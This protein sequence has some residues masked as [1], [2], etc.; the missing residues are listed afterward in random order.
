MGLVANTNLDAI[1]VHNNLTS[2][3]NAVAKSIQRLSSGLRVN[4]AKDDASGFAIAN[5]FKAKTSAMRVASQNAAEGQSMLQVADGGYN[6][7]HEI[8]I[9]MK[10]LAT[11]AASGQV[12]AASSNNEYQLLGE[13][14]DRI[15]NSTK[16]SNRTLINDST[17]L[18][19]MQVGASNCDN[20]RIGISLHSATKA[21]LGLASSSGSGNVS[22]NFTN[23][24]SVTVSTSTS[25]GLSITFTDSNGNTFSYS[26]PSNTTAWVDNG[27]G[28]WTPPWQNSGFRIVGCT[29]VGDPPLGEDGTFHFK[30]GTNVAWSGAGS[31]DGPTDSHWTTLGSTQQADWKAAVTAGDISTQANALS[32]MSLIDIALTSINSYMGE[33][34]A[35]QNR[36][37]Y[38]VENLA[39]SIENYSASESVI[40]DVDMAAEISTFSKN[41]VLQQ[42]GMA[43]LAQANSAPQQILTLLR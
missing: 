4:S 33:V 1:R 37:Q 16:Y 13:E 9:R 43:M 22:V 25:A 38:T 42:A 24:S 30:P 21:G 41:Q 11:Q 39:I 29:N 15:A 35:Y 28:T 10:A 26:D 14:I 7:I 12:N 36:L 2:T 20:D 34:G 23:C 27:N 31:P 6:R 5:S 19:T 32:A 17:S 3:N 40:R 18:V 8:L